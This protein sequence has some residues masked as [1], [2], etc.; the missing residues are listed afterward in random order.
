[1]CQQRHV[2]VGKSQPQSRPLF[3]SCDFC[4]ALG[5][6]V[7]SLV[8]HFALCV[9]AHRGLTKH[10]DASSIW[11]HNEFTSISWQLEVKAQLLTNDSLLPVVCLC[12]IASDSL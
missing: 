6:T 11:L 9:H 2:H 7:S 8:V 5:E 1:M 3:L 4:H 10:T 12:H